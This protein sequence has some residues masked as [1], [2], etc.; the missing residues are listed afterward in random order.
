VGDARTA[1]VSE[2][3]LRD[4]DPIGV[5]DLDVHPAQEYDHEAERVLQILDNGI[6]RDCRDRREELARYL[7]DAMPTASTGRERDVATTLLKWHA[8]DR[9]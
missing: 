8:A 5:K 1:A 4:W 3:L 7:W 6:G 9:A 2:I